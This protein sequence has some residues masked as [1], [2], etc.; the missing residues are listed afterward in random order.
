MDSD[1][2]CQGYRRG[3]EVAW[4]RWMACAEEVVGPGEQ[5]VPVLDESLRL[6]FDYIDRVLG[7]VIAE[8][9]R[10]RE[11]VLGGALARRT[12]PCA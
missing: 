3:Q 4:Q 10:E 7:R 9:Q 11:A 1:A 5:L 12:R 8:M 2:A 6:L